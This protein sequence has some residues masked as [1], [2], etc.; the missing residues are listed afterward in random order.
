[1]VSPTRTE[2]RFQHHTRVVGYLK[3]NYKK[4]KNTK[5]ETKHFGLVIIATTSWQTLRTACTAVE[6]APVFAIINVI[7]C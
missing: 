6:T 1:M 7:V 2:Q 4:Q 3:R 5:S